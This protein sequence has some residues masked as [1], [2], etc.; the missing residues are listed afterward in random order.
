MQKLRQ[1]IYRPHGH[2]RNVRTV[3]RGTGRIAQAEKRSKTSDSDSNGKIAM[4]GKGSRPRPV[5]RKK[6]SDN[7]DRIFGKRGNNDKAND[8]RQAAATLRARGHDC[9]DNHAGDLS[10]IKPDVELKPSYFKQARLNLEKCEKKTP[11]KE[12][13]SSLF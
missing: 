10:G 11:E 9:H 5:D 13:Q 8:S 1:K 6:Y 12:D 7:Y 4:N 2:C 3:A